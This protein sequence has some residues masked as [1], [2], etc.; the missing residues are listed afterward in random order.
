M[1]AAAEQ[2]ERDAAAAIA[3]DVVSAA[4]PGAPVAKEHRADAALAFLQTNPNASAHATAN[5]L[6]LEG[7]YAPQAATAALTQLIRR[8]LA[9]KSV[10]DGVTVYR[11]A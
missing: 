2:A 9:T 8:G 10:V 6:G 5:A 11:A 3:A 7:N 4:F 1:L